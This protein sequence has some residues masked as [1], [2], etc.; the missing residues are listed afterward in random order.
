MLRPPVSRYE[1][2]LQTSSFRG[3]ISF[4]PL[5]VLLWLLCM[6]PRSHVQ[7]SSMVHVVLHCVTGQD[8]N[9]AFLCIEMLVT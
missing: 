1:S 8:M 9:Y 6:I 7:R 4:M 3:C 2:E 5:L